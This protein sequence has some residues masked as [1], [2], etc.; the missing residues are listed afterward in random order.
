MKSGGKTTWWP[1]MSA[2]F[3]PI[4]KSRRKIHSD[5]TNNKMILVLYLIFLSVSQCQSENLTSRKVIRTNLAF[6]QESYNVVIPE[7]SIGKVYAV[8]SDLNTKMGIS[9][10]EN[11]GISGENFDKLSIRFRIRSGDT[12]GF[13]KA[14]AEKIGDFVFLL[15]RTKTNNMDVLNRERRDSYELEI[16]TR[17]RDKGKILIESLKISSKFEF[18]NITLK[19]SLPAKFQFDAKK[20]RTCN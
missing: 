5:F 1:K 15:I 19:F 16:R 6:T 13:F 7:N 2:P 18:D 20:F 11:S 14:E 17:V 8:P 12:D 3:W 10:S 9:L 4:Y